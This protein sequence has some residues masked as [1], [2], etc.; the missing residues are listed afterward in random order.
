MSAHFL[1][2][3]TALL[4]RG[5]D[6]VNPEPLRFVVGDPALPDASLATSPPRWTAMGA[7][8]KLFYWLF[9]A[10]PDRILELQR[11]LPAEAHVGAFPPR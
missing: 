11:D 9:Q 2:P 5:K 3:T 1:L 10:H 7:S 4:S 6:P 8:D